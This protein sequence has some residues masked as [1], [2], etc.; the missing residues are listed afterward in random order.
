MANHRVYYKGEGGGFP[1]VQAMVNLVC[2]CCMW[3][4]L[5][6]RV[7]QLCINHF[8]WVVCRPVWVNEAC[9]LSLVPSRSSNMPFYPSKCCELGNMPWLLPLPLSFTLTH[10]QVLQGIGNVSPNQDSFGTPPWES[11]DKKSFG[12]GCCGEAYYMGEGGGFPRVWTEVSHVSPELPMACPSTK[13]APKNELTNLLVYL[14]QV[15]VS[16]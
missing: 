8:V 6:P 13:V 9:Q 2:S 12:C 7:L 4:V 11:R 14:M 1:Q 3:L 16:K 10:I 5:A 15:R